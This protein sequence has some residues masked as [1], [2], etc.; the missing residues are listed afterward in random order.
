MRALGLMSGTSVDGVDVALIDSDKQAITITALAP[1]GERRAEQRPGCLRP[2]RPGVR[3]TAGLAVAHAAQAQ[4]GDLQAG[5]A[6]VD[7]VHDRGW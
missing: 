2:Q 7:V 3:A 6:E 5:P 4:P 1:E